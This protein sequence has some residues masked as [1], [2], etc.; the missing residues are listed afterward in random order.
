[1]EVGLGATH[2]KILLLVADLDSVN[3]IRGE[4]TAGISLTLERTNKKQPITP[5]SPELMADILT[6]F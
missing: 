4:G 5:Q 3:G 2:D 6:F 1:M